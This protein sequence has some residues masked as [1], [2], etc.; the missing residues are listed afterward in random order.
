MNLN[1]QLIGLLTL[2]KKEVVRVFRIWKQTLLPPVVTTSLYFLIFGSFIGNRIGRLQDVSY[3]DFI[4]PGLIIMSVLTNAYANVSSSVFGQ[5]FQNNIDELLV[6][7]LE[8]PIILCG[9]LSGGVVRSLVIGTLVAFVS[10]LFSSFK[11]YH[12]GIMILTLLLTSILFSLTG[13]L[14]ALYAKKFDDI[15]VIPT[16]VLTPLTYL[17]GVFYTVS[18]LSPFWQK[19]SIF[20]P[21]LYI[22]NLFRY[23][24]LGI[25][26]INISIALAVLTFL[27]AALWILSYKLLHKGIGLKS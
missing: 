21:I 14:N 16:F 26:D 18:L 25:S 9:F 22:V 8:T 13:F 1:I 23:S 3:I 27:T 7:P 11:V 6:S 10:S 2:T 17:G 24:L 4:V 15:A 20:N 5:K 19:I 12:V